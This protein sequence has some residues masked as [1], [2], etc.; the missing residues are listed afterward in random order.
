MPLYP[1]F[2][3]FEQMKE[4][5]ATQLTRLTQTYSA[6]A[7]EPVRCEWVAGTLY[8]FGSEL[9]TLRIFRATFRADCFQ[10]FSKNLGG[11]YVSFGN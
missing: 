8:I 7:G 6:D 10:G 5:T 4:P 11:F 1:S 2:L 9:A 3:G